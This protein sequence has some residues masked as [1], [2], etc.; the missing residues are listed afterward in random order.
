M[1]S[2]LT[3]LLD[4][5]LI[6]VFI[7]ANLAIGF[8]AHRQ[9]KPGSFVDYAIA[10]KYL[11][12]GVL[13]MT[14]LGTF[15]SSQAFSR[16]DGLTGDGLVMLLALLV[17]VVSFIIIG[18]FIAPQLIYFEKSTYCWRCDANAVWSFGTAFLQVLLAFYALCL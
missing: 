12:R 16:I 11:P 17:M 6:L 1:T 13:L 5:P 8:Y 14:L 2:I 9:S 7:L 3:T 10:S 18:I 4:Y 15:L